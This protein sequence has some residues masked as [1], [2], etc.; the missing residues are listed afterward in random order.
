MASETRV[1]SIASVQVST[2]IRKDPGDLT[3]LADDLRKHGLINPITV[4]DC[5]NGTYQLIAGLHGR[6]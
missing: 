4:M 2:R 3:E 6:E 1:I 5:Q